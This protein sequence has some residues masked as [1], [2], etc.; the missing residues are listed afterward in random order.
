MN[1]TSTK[2]ANASLTA[3]RLAQVQKAF[4]HAVKAAGHLDSRTLPPDLV[5]G[6]TAALGEVSRSLQALEAAAPAKKVRSRSATVA[7]PAAAVSCD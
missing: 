1:N 5:A 2:P 4:G 3:Y 6:L 7:A